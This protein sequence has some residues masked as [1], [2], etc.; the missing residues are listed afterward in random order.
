MALQPARGVEGMEDEQGDALIEALLQQ[1]AQQQEE[2]TGLRNTLGRQQAQAGNLRTLSLLSSLGANPLLQGIRGASGEQGAQLEGLAARTEQRLATQG[3]GMDPSSLARLRLSAERLKRQ[4]NLDAQK[5]ELARQN[6][7]R[8]QSQ[9]GAAREQAGKKEAEQLITRETGLRKEFNALPEVTQFSGLATS[10]NNLVKSASDMSGPGGVATIFNFMK[11]LDPGV[12]VMEGDVQLI[13]NSGGK[14]AAFANL[15]EQALNGNPL[16]KSVRSDLV[17]QGSIL[18][19][20]RKKQVD[21]LAEQYGGIAEQAGVAPA[22]VV[23]QRAPD[24]DLSPPGSTPSARPAP[25][26]GPRIVSVK[27]M[28][29]GELVASLKEG[30]TV[31]V[32]M[33]G[34]QYQTVKRKNGKLVKVKE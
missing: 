22:R 12:A 14:A 34:G 16:P 10:Y 5:L 31:R 32:P 29:P 23:I 28:K 8:L 19:Q 13:K 30:E 1:Q 11:M 27:G 33:G 25:A 7:A 2:R 26:S 15:Y 3:A 6:L 20:G 18:Y 9:A 4:G 24:I 21:K 17:R